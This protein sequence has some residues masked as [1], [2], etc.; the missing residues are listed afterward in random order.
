[1]SFI[2]DRVFS[3]DF[4]NVGLTADE[5]ILVVD[6]RYLKDF[7]EFFQDATTNRRKYKPY[8]HKKPPKNS[9]IIETVLSKIRDLYNLMMWYMIKGR[10]NFLPKLFRNAQLE[11]DK[12]YSGAT[13]IAPRTRTCSN[14]INDRMPYAVG[15]L[16]VENHFSEASKKEVVKS[17]I[18]LNLIYNH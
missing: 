5:S 17:F 18:L 14:A 1:M 11:F 9:R 4:P 10:T 2:V 15:R 12:I 16:Y 6:F 8:T 3:V 7:A 13:S